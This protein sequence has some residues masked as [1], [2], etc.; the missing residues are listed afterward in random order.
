MLIS[1]RKAFRDLTRRKLRSFLTVVGIIIGVG[2]LVAITSTSKNMTAAQSA[3]YNNNSQQDMRWWVSDAPSNLIAALDNVVNVDQAEL[4]ATYYT[5]WQ[6]AGAWR[7]IYFN[8]IADFQDMRVN[9]IDLV[10]GH[11]PGRGETV[12]ASS[13]RDVAPTHIGDELVYRADPGNQ[14]RT[15]RVVGF[16]KSPS[17]PNAAIMGTSVAYALD[18]E[19]RKMYGGAG[20]NQVLVRL[21]DFSP[22]VRADSRAE[23]ERTFQKRGLQFGSY[24]ER[25]PDDYV[26]KRQLDALVLLMTVFSLVGLVI[27]SFLVANTLAAVISEQMGEIGAM[28]AIG[29]T[30]GK[31]VSIYVV[32]G[33]LYGVVGTGLGLA[34]GI[35]GGHAL[36][37]YLGGLFN[38]GIGGISVDAAD[39]LQ[40]IGVGVGVTTLAAFLPAW[41]GTAITVRKALDNYGIT[42]TYGQGAFDRLVQRL[43]RLPRVPAIALRNLARRKGRN[44]VTV[45]AI[46]LAT[47]AFL[48][49]QSTSDSVNLS[50]GNAYDVYGADAWVWFQSPVTEGFAN[51]LR[52]MPEVQAVEAWASSGA[53]VDDLRVTMWGIPPN[54]GLYNYQT[55]ITAGRWLQPDEPESAVVSTRMAESRHLRPGDRIELRVGG[56]NAWLT[57][58]GLVNDNAQGLSSSSRG[59]VFVALDTASRLMNRRDAADFFAVQFTAHDGAS[60]ERSLAAVERKYRDLSP[61][62]LAAYADEQSSLEASRILTI[63]LYAMTVIVALIGGIGVANTLTLNVLERR[64]EIGVMR[65]VGGQNTHL[66]QVFLTEALAMGGFGFLLGL[67]LG[68]PM[69]RGLVWLMEQVLFPLDFIFPVGMVGSAFLFT[70]ALTAIASIGPALGA[71]RLKVSQ[72]LRYE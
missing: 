40:G 17:Y 9:R 15:L 61:G 71:A 19:V 2:G 39:V 60:V 22:S 12:V 18:S 49:A 45:M 13:V 7:D 20:D 30:G 63:L 33:V 35:F 58:V 68:W 21:S 69:A 5:K 25:N 72:A 8:G 70:L 4:R 34:L 46:A 27:A 48:A 42:A 32:A 65:A 47:A 36:L 54:T 43:S 11:W 52:A 31:V 51:T 50:I 14:T 67:A 23:I 41:R 38:L 3:A 1:F 44:A 55:R 62:M 10:E 16:A 37:L 26:G 66:V 53:A 57:I 59:K 64:R 24:W 56:A 28:K 29:A 6:A